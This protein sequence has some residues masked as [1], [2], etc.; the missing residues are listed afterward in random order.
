MSELRAISE[1]R[2]G[3]GT[4][5]ESA[6]GS[7]LPSV[8]ALLSQLSNDSGVDVDMDGNDWGVFARDMTASAS[9]EVFARR[10]GGG[11]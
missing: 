8:K 5:L 1:A 11:R 7:F 9:A 6:P 4:L 3:P 10:G 2:F